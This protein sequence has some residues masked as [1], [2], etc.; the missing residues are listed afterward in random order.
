MVATKLKSRSDR[1]ERAQLS[2]EK[3]IEGASRLALAAMLTRK[4]T[5][6]RS[7]KSDS[8][9][10]SEAA[11]DASKILPDLSDDERATCSSVLFSA[12]LATDAFVSTI[13][14][15]S[16]IWPQSDSRPCAREGYPLRPLN[17]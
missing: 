10:A 11:L 13:V 4:L 9:E 3:A 12:S 1:K 7:A 8:V 16:N 17:G 14:P 15:S 6:R 2:Q 5:L